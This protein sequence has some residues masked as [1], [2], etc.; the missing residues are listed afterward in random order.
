M[1]I[2]QADAENRY[3]ELFSQFVEGQDEGTL[4]QFNEL[5]INMTNSGIAPEVVIEMHALAIESLNSEHRAQIQPDTNQLLPLMEVIMAYGITF[6]Q[7]LDAQRDASE[8]QFLQVLEQSSDLIFITDSCNALTFANPAFQQAICKNRAERTW[9][10]PKFVDHVDCRSPDELWD[11]LNN[12]ETFKGVLAVLDDDNRTR[13]WSVSAFPIRQPQHGN[14]QFVFM[15]E[16]IS[17]QL[18]LSKRLRRSERLATL[19]ELASGISHEFNNIL[20]IISGFAE[21]IRDD[22][23]EQT[24]TAFSGEILKAV[25]KGRNLNEQILS[26]SKDS[27]AQGKP[28]RLE[29]L[30]GRIRE[31]VKTAVGSSIE[32]RFDYPA[33]LIVTLNE[34]HLCQILTNLC[35]NAKHAIQSKG[36]SSTSLITCN[37]R[38]TDGL[39]L[40]SVKDNGV[41]MDST[42]VNSIFEP[43]FTT[44]RTGD[45][46]GL[47]L[48][49]VLKIVDSYHGQIDVASKL[50]RGTEF[51][52]KLPVL[53]GQPSQPLM[54]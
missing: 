5:G 38:A 53:Y 1:V 17:A 12:G 47:G 36:I 23:S 10:C 40:L 14:Q 30:I 15:A 9:Q 43:F 52:L 22:P 19:G 29:T 24:T 44:K 48:A 20:L 26:F 13:V 4:L 31:L 50:G 8:A 51:K 34:D 16:D 41:G 45:G 21:L 33:D 42:L 3:T 25:E 28:V 2:T 37:F 11:T 49:I 7:Q 27:E 6:R 39:L 35:I 54:V 46:S 32:L 18:A